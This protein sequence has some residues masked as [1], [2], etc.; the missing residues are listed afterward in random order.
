[1]ALEIVIKLHNFFM[2]PKSAIFI[3][4]LNKLLVQTKLESN[5]HLLRLFTI[6]FGSKIDILSRK[7]IPQSSEIT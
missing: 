7:A 2:P 4:F 5:I 3:Y 1:M 6:D